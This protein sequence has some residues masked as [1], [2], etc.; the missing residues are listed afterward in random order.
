[1]HVGGPARYFIDVLDTGELVE[2]LKFA[3]EKGLPYF[4]LGGGSNIL[5]SDKGFDGLVIRMGIVG[6]KVLKDTEEYIEYE[7]GAGENWDNFVKDAVSKNLYGIENMSHVPGSVGAS[8]VQN[9]GCY[10]QEVSETVMQVKALDVEALEEVVLSNQEL[11]FSYRKSSLNNPNIHKGKYIVTHVIFRLNKKGELNMS[12]GDIQKY[13]LAHPRIVPSLKS[14]REAVISIRNSKFPFPDSP[15]NGTCG[16]FWNAETID[17]E[18]Y[19]K[20]ISVLRAKG[21]TKQAEDMINK[22]SV[23]KV[24][25]GF[26][27]PYGVF[28]EVLGFKGKPY[29]GAKVLET[30]SGVINNFT[31]KASAGDVFNL[32]KEVIDRVHREFGIRLKM[33]PE[34]VGE[35]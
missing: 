30:H 17:D 11:Q 14:I 19:E 10:G 6:K 24:A 31:G 29:G 18:T 20:I 26:K 21:F 9:V 22:K 4:I 2:A 1:M 35:F 15:E 27:V 28:V 3:K 33:E 12:Y 23:F 13:F 5:I 8:V 34:L 25:Q 16:S 32:A 7:V